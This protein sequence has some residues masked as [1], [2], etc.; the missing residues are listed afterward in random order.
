MHPHKI[1]GYLQMSSFALS[2]IFMVNE[3][4]VYGSASYT[5]IAKHI[6]ESRALS[7]TNSIGIE[8]FMSEVLM[9]RC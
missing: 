7:S 1:I 2:H 6:I 8:T 4:A 9:N 3:H 5:L